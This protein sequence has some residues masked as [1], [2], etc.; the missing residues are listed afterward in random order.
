MASDLKYAL[1]RMGYTW[2][3]ALAVI[4][5]FAV[6]MTVGPTVEATYA[7]VLSEQKVMSLE[8]ADRTATFEIRVHK[9][10]ECRLEDA[11]FVLRQG[12]RVTWVTVFRADGTPVT[13]GVSYDTGWLHLGP[14]HFLYPPGFPD[15]AEVYGV[16]YYDCHAGWLTRQVFGPV[17]LS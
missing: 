11:A 8:V 7:P 4:V 3:T 16:L 15:P 17:R 10:R 1:R 12:E 13:G 5:G 6:V 2:L 14:F 9:V